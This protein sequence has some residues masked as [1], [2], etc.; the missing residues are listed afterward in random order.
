[1]TKSFEYDPHCLYL[2]ATSDI[3]YP[4]QLSVVDSAIELF[5]YIFPVQN[6][7]THE[8]VIDQLLKLATYSPAK[9]SFSRK[10]AGPINALIAIIGCLKYTADQKVQIS[11]EFVLNSII[12]I[13][14]VFLK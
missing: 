2:N 5:A 1:L 9:A 8:T 12:T 14:K 13:V 7:S 3:P 6:T 4:S 10:I 11:S